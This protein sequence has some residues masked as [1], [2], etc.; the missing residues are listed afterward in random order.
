MVYHNRPSSVQ[1]GNPRIQCKVDNHHAL[2]TC[3]VCGAKWMTTMLHTLTFVVY[4]ILPQ[5][6]V[7]AHHVWCTCRTTFLS[8][9]WIT[10]MLCALAQVGNPLCFVHLPRAKWIPTMLPALATYTS[11]LILLWCKV[12]N[13]HASSAYTSFFVILWCRTAFLGAKW[14]LRIALYSAKHIQLT[15]FHDQ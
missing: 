8:A 15:S 11:L 10:T 2:C 12:D 13:H 5:C 6:K 4:H 14:I 9:K 3:H 1:S 7:E